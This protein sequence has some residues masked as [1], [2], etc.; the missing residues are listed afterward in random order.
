MSFDGT[1]FDN[2]RGRIAKKGKSPNLYLDFFYHGVRIEKSTGLKD[3]PENLLKAEAMLRK[4]LEMKKAGTLEFGKIFP[5]AAPK[6]IEFHTRL[7]KADYAPNAKNLT[8]GHYVRNTW[9]PTIWA[10]YPERTKGKDFQSV[11][12][13]HLLPFF[14]KHSFFHITGP[15][16][17]RFIATL[18][19]KSGPKMGETLARSTMVNI[20]QVF[21]TIWNDAVDEHRWLLHD[22]FKGIKKHL[23]KKT[24]K[25][26]EIFRFSEWQAIMASIPAHYQP[27]VKLMVLTGLMASEIASLRPQSI[28]NGYLY[29]EASVVRGVESEELKTI[30][31]QRRFRITKKL[32]EILEQAQTSAKGGRLFT[33]ADGST[34]TAEKFQRRVWTKALKQAGVKYRKPYTTRHTFAAWC[35]TLG[36]DANRLVYL[37]GH[38]SKQMVFEVYGRYVEDLEDDR[39]QILAYFGDDFLAKG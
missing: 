26:V 15:E 14:E 8:F 6:E 32:G 12:D 1:F 38:G 37:M 10:N 34:F 11:I 5:K 39:E 23:P 31:R 18:K 24:K 22:P 3:T 25:T 16:L 17:Q 27:V 21:R 36:L 28:R 2:L 35:L 30:H 9:Y 19:H 20:L 4:I 13:F 7:E 33:M 29:I